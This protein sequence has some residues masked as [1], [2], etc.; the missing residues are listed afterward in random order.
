MSDMIRGLTHT[1]RITVPVNLSNITACELWIDSTA[2]N[3]IKH[4]MDDLEI[5]SGT[6]SVITY[7]LAEAESLKFK[8]RYVTVQC[9]WKYPDGSISGTTCADILIEPAI[10]D[11][12][13]E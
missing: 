3:R 5:T 13:I 8:S 6:E 7:K 10:W 11:G 12:E 4:N 2:G 1:L 9:R